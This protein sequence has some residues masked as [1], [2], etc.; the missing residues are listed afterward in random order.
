MSDANFPSPLQFLQE[1]IY[2][3]RSGTN[4]IDSVAF[5]DIDP[6]PHGNEK[7]IRVVSKTEYEL[8]VY[9]DEKQVPSSEWLIEH[10]VIKEDKDGKRY[11]V[12]KNSLEWG[13]DV[14]QKK[15]E[16]HSIRYELKCK[17]IFGD[18]KFHQIVYKF[19]R[20]NRNIHRE[21]LLI[22]GKSGEIVSQNN[23]ESVSILTMP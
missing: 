6:F 22:D 3:N 1:S 15:A 9:F 18:D 13:C 19:I 10:I 11:I 23:Y 20:E 4:I 7:S 17:T 12:F 21:K 14:Y 5:S 16:N 2:I 8:I